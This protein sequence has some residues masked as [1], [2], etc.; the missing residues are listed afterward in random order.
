MSNEIALVTG[1]SHGIG[2]EVV[3]QL[4]QKGLSVVLTARNIEKGEAAT[5]KQGAL[6]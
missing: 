6:D 4:A 1:A 5:Q 3:R 2:F